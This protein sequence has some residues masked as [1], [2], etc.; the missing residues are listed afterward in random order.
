MKKF[1]IS[2]DVLRDLTTLGYHI[3]QVLP[4]GIF[5][6]YEDHYNETVPLPEADQNNF[7]LLEFGLYYR[8]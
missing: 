3:I 6:Y 4:F 5:F 1:K 7:V 8:F 2:N